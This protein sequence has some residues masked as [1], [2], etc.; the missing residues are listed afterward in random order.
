MTEVDVWIKVMDKLG[1]FFIEEKCQPGDTNVL[2]YVWMPTNHTYRVYFNRKTE[3]VNSIFCI[4]GGVTKQTFYNQY[5]STFREIKL[6]Q[7]L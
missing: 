5:A 4:I 1:F 7:L 2:E 6:Q 3:E